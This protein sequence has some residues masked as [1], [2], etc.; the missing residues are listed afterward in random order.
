MDDRPIGAVVLAAGASRR[1]GSPK[2][3]AMVDG[4]TLLQHAT[5]LALDAGLRPVVVVVPVW[6]ARPASWTGD[7]LR[8]VRNPFPERGM[9]LSLRL[10][11]GALGDEPA[12]AVVLLGDQPRVPAATLSAI[13]AARGER[14]VV[15]AEAGGVLAPPVL[16]ERSHFPLVEQL[17]GD[18]GLRG[19]LREQ[20]ELVRAVPV[21][22]HPTD[23]DTPDDLARI[24]QP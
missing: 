3:L 23:I 7:A 11:F 20:A 4:R 12:A 16:L 15:A 22:A 18:T 2:L 5:E 17:A 21:H 19:V 13:L 6:L 8:W 1:Y 24:V 10:G 9:S 14:P